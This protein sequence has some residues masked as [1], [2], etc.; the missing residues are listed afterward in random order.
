MNQYEQIKQLAEQ[1]R[2]ETRVKPRRELGGKLLAQLSKEDVRRRLA[3]EA[4]PASTE[5]GDFSVAAQRCIALSEF[6]TLIMKGVIIVA[7]STG[8]GKKDRKKNYDD[9][10]L[11]KKLLVCCDTPDQVDNDG[12]AIPRFNRKMVRN[13]LKYCLNQL[14]DEESVE[15]AEV[16]MLDM[17]NHMC[18]RPEYVGNFK[19]HAD[20][21]RILDELSER[22]TVNVEEENNAVFVCAARV[23]CSLFETSRKLG[24]QVHV[25]LPDCIGIISGWCENHSSMTARHGSS[26]TSAIPHFFNALASLIYSHPEH[27]IGPIKRYGR[28]IL[29]FCKRSYPNADALNKDA[30]NHYLLAHL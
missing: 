6:W 26:S 30:L 15:L 27:A 2:K 22:L 5:P 20:F 1:F 28:N 19:Y 16:E 3:L 23:F 9:V 12:I 24:I 8:S 21:Q 11:P 25:F 4:T 29:R 18:S 14:D 17:L 10:T 13:I 7:Q